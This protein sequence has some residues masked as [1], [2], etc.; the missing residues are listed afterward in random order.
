[1]LALESVKLIQVPSQMRVLPA[2]KLAT[3]GGPAQSMK[4]RFK[5]SVTAVQV[6]AG[7]LV[8]I[9][10]VTHPAAVSNTEG[11]YVAASKFTLSKVPVPS[12]DHV[13]V[14]ALPPMDALVIMNVS[15]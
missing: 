10:K 1:M 4:H 9:T 12:V 7:S 11:V 3:G 6:P 8:V 5:L 14:E 2:A 13:D 15:V